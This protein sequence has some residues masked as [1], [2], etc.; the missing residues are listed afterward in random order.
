MVPR[1]RLM[2]AQRWQLPQGALVKLGCVQAV[3]PRLSGFERAALIIG[4]RIARCERGGDRQHCVRLAREPPEELGHPPV[5]LFRKRLRV[6]QILV[7][8]GHVILRIGAQMLD[9]GLTR[10]KAC[11]FRHIDH[12]RPNSRDFGK[13]QLVDFIR[14]HIGGGEAPDAVVV[15]VLTPRRR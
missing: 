5:N 15:I 9:K 11:A 14:A 3:N 6:A 7:S 1:Y 13:A 2:H 10:F 8:I 12:F 4:G